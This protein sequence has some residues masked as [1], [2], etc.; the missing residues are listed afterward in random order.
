MRE[1]KFR[2]WDIK[3]KK[4]HIDW[5]N[6]FPWG[7]KPPDTEIIILDIMPLDYKFSQYT[8]LKDRNGKEIYEGDIVR[9]YNWGRNKEEITINPVK[10]I[11][12]LDDGCWN[13]SPCVVEDQYDF[14][15]K[16]NGTAFEII[17]NL[18]ENPEL[19]EVE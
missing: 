19:L 4:W 16:C 15:T 1:I 2:A 7:I 9:I 11:F 18:Y 17:G 6:M 14:Y 13:T 8:G 3:R 5:R 12:D 10:I